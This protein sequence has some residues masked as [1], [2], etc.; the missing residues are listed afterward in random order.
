MIEPDEHAVV[1]NSTTAN[2][3]LWGAYLACSWTWCIGMFLPAL[4]LRDFGWAGLVVFAVP[5]VLGAAAMGWVLTSRKES[6]SMVRRHPR[7]VWW[8]SAVTIAYHAFWLLWVINTVLKPAL[9]MSQNYL[10]GAGA[11]VI[12][13]WFASQ[14]ASYFNRMPQLALALLVFSVAVLVATLVLPDLDPSIAR[15]HKDHPGSPAALWMLPV[16]TFGFL[17]CPYLDV[18]FHH[19]RQSLGSRRNGRLGFTIGF[20]VFFA[21]MIFLTTQYAGLIIDAVEGRPVNPTKTAWI[22]AALF[23]HILCQWVFT[24]RVHLQQ[25]K[26]IPGNTPDQR[27][28]LGLALLAALIGFLAHNLPMH[29]GLLGGEI[30]YRV[31]LG[32]YGLLFPTYV[33]YRIVMARNG[34]KPISLTAMWVAIAVAA[35]MFWMGFM[36]RQSIWLAPGVGVVLLVA[37]IG[38]INRKQGLAGPVSGQRV[39]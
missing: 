9:P 7:G 36:E 14:R 39:G 28:L 25:V 13:F 38:A 3:V 21:A 27:V 33:L 12:A 2:P 23:A 34:H 29:A 4:M 5:N 24:V 26:T 17:L 31:F 35:P 6:E 10:F 22:G 8:F 15:L 16:S 30:I 18:T 19:A 11:L 32:A 20:G 1:P 37:A